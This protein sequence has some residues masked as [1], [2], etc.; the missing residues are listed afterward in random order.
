MLN[1]N[2]S[3][4]HRSWTVKLSPNARLPQSVPIDPG[5]FESRSF[6][7]SDFAAT[8]FPSSGCVTPVSAHVESGIP[9]D[10]NAGSEGVPPLAGR[11]HRGETSE[12]VPPDI[13]MKHPRGVPPD[14]GLWRNPAVG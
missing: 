10:E 11:S 5:S 8:G 13:A 14:I 12:G 7:K 6:P 2:D 3:A 9:V 4:S 1:S